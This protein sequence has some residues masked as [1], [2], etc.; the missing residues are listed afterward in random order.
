MDESGVNLAL[1][2]LYARA[3][4]GVRAVASVPQNYGQS[5]TVLAAL[6]CGGIQAAFIVPGATDR[7]VFLSFLEQ[8]LAPQLKP[9]AMVVM[10]NL[11]AHKGT[12]VA[13][14]IQKTGAQLCYLPP[15]SPDYNPIEAAWS[16][17]KNWL[18]GVGARTR[19]TLYRSLPTALA[20]ITAHDA[21][22]W[23]RHCGYALH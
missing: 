14:A 15:Y 12:A 9:G 1:T 7:A 21:Q 4:R 6:G 3:P 2:R 8:V 18:R 11:T 17:M 20:Q 10:D 13:E 23:F 22:A 19:Q 5:Q 16:K